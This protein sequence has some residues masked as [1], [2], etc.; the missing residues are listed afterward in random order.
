[1]KLLRLIHTAGQYISH[2][3]RSWTWSL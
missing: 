2:F 3:R 1:M